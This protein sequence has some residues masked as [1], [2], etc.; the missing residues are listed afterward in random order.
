MPKD[1]Q[2]LNWEEALN[3]VGG[4]REFL[5]EVLQD[6]FN[7]SE[8]AEEEISTGIDNKDFSAVQKAAHRIKG[9]ASY[10]HCEILR[11]ISL[12]LQEAGH[13]GTLNPP[14]PAKLLE[15]IQAMFADFKKA[16]VDLKNEVQNK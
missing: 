5:N 8:A 10:L 12:Q 6:L 13:A 16:L 7:E 15:Q 1:F 14:N 2:I 4:D 9:S 11:E 3:Q